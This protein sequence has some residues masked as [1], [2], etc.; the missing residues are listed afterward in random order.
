MA[1]RWSSRIEVEPEP[2][3]DPVAYE[4][5]AYDP[6]SPAPPAPPPPPSPDDTSRVDVSIISLRTDP[7]T[8]PGTECR[9]ELDP[10][11]ECHARSTSNSRR[12]AGVSCWCGWGC[13]EISCPAVGVSVGVGM[14][15]VEAVAEPEFDLERSSPPSGP[16]KRAIL[17][18]V[19]ELFDPRRTPPAPMLLERPFRA[20]PPVVLAYAGPA[21]CAAL[22]SCLRAATFTAAMGSSEVPRRGLWYRRSMVIATPLP[23]AFLELDMHD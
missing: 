21:A 6:A 15:V 4:P 13:D 12:S 17:A 23:L 8:D 14:G 5:I 18:L 2:A 22:T 20:M 10:E 7:D 16:R 3:Y 9:T 11:S 1:L 19:F